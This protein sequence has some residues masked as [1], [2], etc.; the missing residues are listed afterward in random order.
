MRRFS[1]LLNSGYGVAGAFVGLVISKA[2]H[3]FDIISFS[4]IPKFIFIVA[5]GATGEFFGEWIEKR[6][7]PPKL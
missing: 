6:K 4:T 1:W 5:C 3:N 2:L 7:S